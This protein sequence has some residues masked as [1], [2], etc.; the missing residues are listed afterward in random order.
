MNWV[1]KK[2]VVT[3]A[4]GFIGAWLCKKLLEGKAEVTALVHSGTELLEQHGISEKLRV[5]KADVRNPAELEKVFGEKQ[6][7]CFHLAAKSSTRDAAENKD[8]AFEINVK[9]TRNVLETAAKAG[10]GFVFVSSIKTY[11]GFTEKC[12][13]EEQELLGKSNY[14][15]SK[16][17]AEA[18]CK[19]AASKKGMSV[20]IARVGNVFGGYDN[21][22]E[23]LVPEA[24]KHILEGTPP[25]I[26]GKGESLLDFVYVEDAA[27]GLML[28]GEKVL[29]EKLEAEAYNIGS[30]KWHS[31]LGMVEMLL[32]ISGSDLKPLFKGE[33][34]GSKECLCIK[35]AERELHWKPK[36]GLKQGL[37]KTLEHFKTVL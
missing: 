13:S 33:E 34:R 24:I 25:Q 8:D 10:S 32:E 30:G 14:A 19:G 29:N 2:V 7:V 4:N 16:I 12:F 36:N 11:G 9:G 1:E 35:K 23:R 28:I 15:L 5:V 17:G 18:E 27:E 37:E 22:L 3:G 26:N 31:V 21:N 6:D 20:A